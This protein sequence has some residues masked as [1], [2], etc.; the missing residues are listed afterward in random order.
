MQII[1]EYPDLTEPELT[2]T[3]TA[4][5][6]AFDRLARQF[7]VFKVETIADC[8]VAVTGLPK[9]QPR[10]AVIMSRFA[11]ACTDRF[12]Q[13]LPS[14]ADRLGDETFDLAIRFGVRLLYPPF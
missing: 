12:E 1:Q 3:S 13:L 2:C 7:N 5:D 4:F 10:H 11:Q 8:Y 9:S 6:R 14:L